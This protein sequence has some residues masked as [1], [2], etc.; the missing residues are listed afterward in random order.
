MGG[1]SVCTLGA[2]I[3]PSARQSLPHLHARGFSAG[4]HAGYEIAPFIPSLE[5][6]AALVLGARWRSAGSAP[7]VPCAALNTVR[8]HDMHHRFPRSHFSL[9]FTHWDRWCGTEHPAY[10]GAV[11]SHFSGADAVQGGTDDALLRDA[12]AAE[13]RVMQAAAAKASATGVGVAAAAS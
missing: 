12:A 6:V 13:A 2:L 7:A 5:A 10:R 11:E 1:L 3:T 4:G 8:H 9:Y